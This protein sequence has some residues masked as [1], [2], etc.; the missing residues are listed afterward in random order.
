LNEIEGEW[1]FYPRILKKPPIFAKATADKPAAFSGFAVVAR[2]DN[3]RALV[4][5]AIVKC[6][7][8]AIDYAATGSSLG[9]SMPSIQ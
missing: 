8:W 1:F 3:G 4:P 9:S 7:V 2:T 5:R 6:S